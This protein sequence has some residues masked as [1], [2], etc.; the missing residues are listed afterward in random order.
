[1]NQTLVY[2]KTTTTIRHVPMSTHVRGERYLCQWRLIFSYKR[3]IR[4][5]KTSS[6]FFTSSFKDMNL[7]FYFSS[8]LFSFQFVLFTR[9]FHLELIKLSTLNQLRVIFLINATLNTM[10]K[11]K[12]LFMIYTGISFHRV[13]KVKVFRAGLVA[14][15]DD[16][17][18]LLSLSNTRAHFKSI[19][20]SAVHANCLLAHKLCTTAGVTNP[21]HVVQHFAF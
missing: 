3:L 20:R 18:S 16:A 4:D 12:S 17:R 9:F 6:I 21:E 5:Y 10:K 14:V 13:L 8:L 1:M 15:D 11:Y 7:V 2:V 19:K